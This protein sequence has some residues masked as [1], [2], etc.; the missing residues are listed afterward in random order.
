MHDHIIIR[1]VPGTWVLRAADAIIGESSHALELTEGDRKP[2]I[3]VPRAD[4]LPVFLEEN[5]TPAHHRRQGDIRYFHIHTAAGP[6][7]DAVKMLINP[8]A[9]FARLSDYL[10]FDPD[11]VT[12]EQV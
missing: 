12:I 8:S 9:D 7:R 2:E 6:M 10:S 11:R 5:P 3:F 1:S 4:I